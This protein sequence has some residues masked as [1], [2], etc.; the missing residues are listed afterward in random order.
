MHG[1]MSL[2]KK[3]IQTIKNN[4]SKNNKTVITKNN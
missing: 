2:R 1:G 4:Q 3:N